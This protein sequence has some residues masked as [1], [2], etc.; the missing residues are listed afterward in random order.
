MRLAPDAIRL[1]DIER[2]LGEP[3]RLWAGRCYEISCSVIAAGL[4]DG[5][6]VY[7]H[8]L[9]KIHPHSMF[10]SG[11][12]D[13][14]RHGWIVLKSD[15]RVLD[16]TRWVFE[17]VD[18]YLYLGSAGDYDEGG[19]RLRT[20]LTTPCPAFSADTGA[21]KTVYDF[22]SRILSAGAWIHVRQ[23]VGGRGKHLARRE[24]SGGQVFWLANLPL[25]NLWP[26]AK[27]IYGAID[28][29]GRRALIPI[30]NRRRV[31][32]GRA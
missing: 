14:C 4:V 20:S 5:V 11:P 24:L 32:R 10:A 8:Y 28:A 17:A 23:L 13:F 27:E 26:F 7:G 18:P 25:G 2:A 30:D 31:E 3:A 19:D 16:P 9:G 21:K 29:I 22:S 12:A 1:A 6:A 15:A